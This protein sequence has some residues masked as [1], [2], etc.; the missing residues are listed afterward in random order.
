MGWVNS[1]P[2]FCDPAETVIC[3]LA[4]DQLAQHWHPP[5]HHLDQIA[6]ILPSPETLPK[7]PAPVPAPTA[8]VPDCT[9]TRPS[10]KPLSSVDVYVDDFVGLG[11]GSKQQLRSV[12]SILFHCLDE[13]MR[14]IESQDP[15]TRQEPASVK[16]LKKGNAQWATRKLYEIFDSL[17]HSKKCIALKK[18]HQI[19][20]ELCSMS[21]AIPGLHS[22]FSLLQ[23]AFRHTK[24]NHVH[25]TKNLHDSLHNMQYLAQDLA[26]RPTRLYYYELVPDS[27]SVI[28][29]CDAAK[30]GM[31]GVFFAPTPAATT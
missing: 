13:V 15:D 16:K 17:P 25:H 8:P 20:G 23:E 27:P 5:S 10:R 19:L 9:Y 6:E 30:P 31:G 11:Q 24:K 14:P 22:W 7:I 28:G 21:L 26:L 3:Y 29:A 12:H 1:P 18:W 4:N 2:L